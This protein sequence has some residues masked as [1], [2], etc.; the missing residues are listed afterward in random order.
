MNLISILVSV[1]RDEFEK[2]KKRKKDEAEAEKKAEEESQAQSLPSG[3]PYDNETQSE[4]L[5]DGAHLAMSIG[6]VLLLVGFVSFVWKDQNR[7]L[8]IAMTV[9]IFTVVIILIFVEM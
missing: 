1:M 9:L 8:G 5:Q 3:R 4:Y 7:N 2:R 6:L